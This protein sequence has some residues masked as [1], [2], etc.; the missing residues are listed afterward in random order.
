[1]TVARHKKLVMA[2]P[3]RSMSIGRPAR[4]CLAGGIGAIL[5]L[6]A[7]CQTHRLDDFRIGGTTTE[8]AG[9]VMAYVV[10][11]GIGIMRQELMGHQHEAGCAEAAL[12]GAR[13]NESLLDGR[14]R[15]TRIQ[16]LD[17][18]DVLSV[19]A[20]CEIEAARHRD[21]VNQNGATAA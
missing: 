8:I 17:C 7:C 1:M 21:I 19:H 20:D 15:A 14:Q 13:I 6:Q 3:L 11:A 9:K 18:Y 10:L 16:M 5:F 2:N 12:E 4:E